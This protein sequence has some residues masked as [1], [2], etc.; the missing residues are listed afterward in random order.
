MEGGLGEAALAPPEVTFAD[1]QALAE[2]R[3]DDKL[4]QRAFVQL[5]VIENEELLDIAGAIDEDAARAHHRHADD[6]TVLAS[7]ALQSTEGIVADIEREAE[8][9]QAFR[10]WRGVGSVGGHNASLEFTSP[11]RSTQRKTN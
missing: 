4:R 5:G 9:G 3:A 8:D 1:E 11:K 6:V 2:Q 7:K 10:A